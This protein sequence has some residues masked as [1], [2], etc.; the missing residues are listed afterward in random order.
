MLTAIAAPV[1]LSVL[2]GLVGPSVA[3]AMRPGTA[4]RLVS[5]AAFIAA[6]ATGFSLAVSAFYLL[7]RAAGVAAI[8]H[9]SGAALGGLPFVPWLVGLP[10]AAAMLGLLAAATVHSVRVARRLWSAELVCRGLRPTAGTRRIVIVEDDQ[11]TAYAVPGVRGTIVVSTAMLEALTSAE[12]RVLLAHESAHLVHRHQ[13]WIQ[14]TEVAAA[15]NP[16]LRR[17][18]RVVRYVAERWADED[19]ALAVGDRRVTARAIA[20]AALAQTYLGRQPS[21]QPAAAGLRVTGADV[22]RRVEALL[23]PPSQVRSRAVSSGVV[24]LVLLCMRSSA[25]TAH[26]TERSF[27]RARLHS[28]APIRTTVL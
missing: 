25:L 18:P 9:W 17:L 21:G 19:A 15:A 23:N 26:A 14:L 13:L 6:L 1:A 2:L 27:E 5:V 4:V 20:R 12:Q 8:G 24:M 3:P 16:F 28:S 11:P 7:A 22:P 10:V